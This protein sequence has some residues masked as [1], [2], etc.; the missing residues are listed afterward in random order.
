MQDIKNVIDIA[1]QTEP[2]IFTDEQLLIINELIKYQDY[3]ENKSFNYIV[4]KFPEYRQ[5][6]SGK[7]YRP[8]QVPFNYAKFIV[9][10]LAAW[11]FE[12]SIDFNCTSE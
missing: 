8:A 4:E 6:G 12:E 7:D 9:D 1:K 11:Q 5:G 3:Y 2:T 10:K